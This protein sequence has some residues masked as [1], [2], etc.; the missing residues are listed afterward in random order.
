MPLRVPAPVGQPGWQQGKPANLEPKAT[1]LLPARRGTP[2]QAPSC[3]PGQGPRTHRAKMVGRARAA[4][5]PGSGGP[6]LDMVPCP[7]Q[8][9]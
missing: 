9:R 7:R 8:P 5:P 4:A 2:P 1:M 6:G 3:L